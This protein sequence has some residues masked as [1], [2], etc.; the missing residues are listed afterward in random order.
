M[1]T[2]KL[3]LFQAGAMLILSWLCAH[4]LW[5]GNWTYTACQWALLPVAGAVSAYIITLRGV[6]NYL[7]WILPPLMAVAGHY[8]AFFYPQSSAGPLFVC[9]VVSVVGAAAGDVVKKS[10]NS[11]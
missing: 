10:H 6:N 4:A 11:K 8:L 5:L 7:A 3:L 2:L 9:A 1:K